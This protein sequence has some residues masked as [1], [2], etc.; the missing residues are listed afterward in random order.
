MTT[1]PYFIGNLTNTPSINNTYL[2]DTYTDDV[3]LFTI[4]GTESINLNLHNITNG[5]DA[6]LFLFRDRGTIGVFDSS[7]ELIQ[8][9]DL[10]VNRDDSINYIASPDNYIAQVKRYSTGTVNYQLDLSATSSKAPPNLLPVEVNGGVLYQ[11]NTYKNS[12]GVGNNNTSEIYK[13]SLNQYSNVNISLT[14]LTSD[15]DIRIIQDLNNNQIVDSGEVSYLFA[16]TN[17]STTNE[18]LTIELPSGLFYV[19]VYQYQGETNYQLQVEVFSD[20]DINGGDGDDYL[21]GGNGN[22]TIDGKG[23]NDYLSGGLGSDYLIGGNGNDT[24]NGDDGN[25]YLSGGRGNDKLYG[26]NGD[27][28]LVG[29]GNGSYS[30]SE[31]DWLTGGLGAD[32]FGLGYNGSFTDVNYTGSGYAVITDFSYWED[33]KIRLGGVIG[34]YTVDYGSSIVGG[35]ARDTQIFYFGDLIGVVQDTTNVIASRDFLLT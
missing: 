23:G 2:N 25:D 7:D 12:G 20:L 13:F 31:I 32:V 3:Y 26:G 33:D 14:G 11:G 16:S 24:I 6:D 15:A 8:R 9:S 10:G 28:Y 27:D 21:I 30:T 29:V 34:N 18:N 22:D 35:N 4:S 5:E 17:S 19:Q 1:T